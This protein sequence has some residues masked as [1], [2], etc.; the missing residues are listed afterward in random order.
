L[1]RFSST[2]THFLKILIF[3][4]LGLVI[5]IPFNDIE[6]LVKS[7]IMFI[8]YLIIRFLA[9]SLTFNNTNIELKERIFMSLTA[10]KGI[11][12]AVVV[13]T[14][15]SYVDTLS[16]LKILLDLSLLFILYSIIVASITAKLNSYF[17]SPH[18]NLKY[19]KK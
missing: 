3:I 12:V 11:A 17:V 14:L 4:L 16:G 13:F 19:I 9:V 18:H 10:S 8:L 1:K 2:F 7:L 6:F 5:K 15:L